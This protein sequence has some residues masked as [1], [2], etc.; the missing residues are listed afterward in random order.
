MTSETHTK[1][2]KPNKKRTHPSQLSLPKTFPL[3]FIQLTMI[4]HF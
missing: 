4:W 1:K 2:A 3:L